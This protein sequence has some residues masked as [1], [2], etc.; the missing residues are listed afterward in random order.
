MARHI[1]GKPALSRHPALSAR[2]HDPAFTLIELMVV[3]AIIAILAAILL[4][5]LSKAKA[6]A[7]SIK[8]Q[9][10]L[11]QWGL[12]LNM[13]LQALPRSERCRASEME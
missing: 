9:S 10:N 4:L 1:I 8:C 13:Y 11:K 5:S 2:A 6:S 7:V 3:V 12:A